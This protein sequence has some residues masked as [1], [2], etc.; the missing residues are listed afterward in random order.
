MSRID[1]RVVTAP[2]ALQADVIVIGSG[3]AGSAAAR[4]AAG[5]GASV[6]VVEEG[7]WVEPE[8]F[9]VGDFDAFAQLYRQMSMSVTLGPALTPYI[10]G[11]MVGGSSPPNGAICWPL[12]RHVHAEWVT[13]DPALGDALPWAIIE[14]TSA[15]LDVRQN[16]APTDPRI[17]GRKNALMAIGADALGLAHGPIRRNV[18]GCEGLGRCMQGCPK[19]RKQ[20]VDRTFLADAE[21]HGATVLSST[22]VTR[23]TTESGRATGAMATTAGGAPVR[24]RAD[25]AVILAAS[26]VQSPALLMSSGIDQGPVGQNFQCH[27]GVSM[28][29]W[30]SEPVRM[31]EG[32]TQGHDTTGLL[33]E[34]LKFEVLGFGLA[35][36]AA[37]VPGV[38]RRFVRGLEGLEHW[39]DWGACVRARARGR[40]RLIRGRPAVFFHPTRADVALYR[41]GLRVMGE[42][43]LAAGAEFVAPGVRGF[44]ERVTDRATLA[45]LEADGP[46]RAGAFT[47]VIT[48]MFGTCRMGS[49]PA[50]AV[51]RPD[52]RHHAVD[53]LYVADSSVFPTNL[54]VNPQSSIWTLATLCGRRAIGAAVDAPAP[55]FEE[56][57]WTP[58]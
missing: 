40:V 8:E 9:A 56:P 52:F 36:L 30:F 28:A 42:M 35:V 46:T 24:L 51:V 5:H 41:R 11:R 53:R 55:A 39:V 37:R 43:M 1:G 3:P 20:S 7:R 13:A 17:A 22:R 21:A 25:R 12:P 57:R 33:H 45:R 50:T 16:V 47:S 18:R 44:A 32:A 49:D 23:I 4:E 38:G 19:G 54:G 34:G 2:C 48:H 29:G 27:P 15:A 31:W 6:I 58:R 10:Q 14:A 26:A